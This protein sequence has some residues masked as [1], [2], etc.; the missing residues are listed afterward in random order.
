MVAAESASLATVGAGSGEP[1][2]LSALP[3][4]PSAR[5]PA[6]GEAPAAP[7]EQPLVSPRAFSLLCPMPPPRGYPLPHGDPVKRTDTAN[8]GAASCSTKCCTAMCRTKQSQVVLLEA[9]TEPGVTTKRWTFSRSASCQRTAAAVIPS[10]WPDAC[11][12]Q[13][14]AS[15]E[16]GEPGHFICSI[17]TCRITIK[18]SCR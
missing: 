14:V 8:P 16:P 2:R 15:A 17:A 1:G 7:R 3:L 11:P 9:H 18:T 13:R 10:P 6:G 12:S 4:L 5:P